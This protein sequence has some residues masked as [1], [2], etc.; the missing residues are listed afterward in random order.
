MASAMDDDGLND[1]GRRDAAAAHWVAQATAGGLEAATRLTWAGLVLALINVL[2][3]GTLSPA[4]MVYLALGIVAALSGAVQ[5]W[6]LVRVTI[7]CRL[8]KVLADVMADSDAGGLAGS[9][10][11]L[12]ALDRA[13]RQLGWLKPGVP[14]AASRNLV[15]R[16][17]GAL[18]LLHWAAV[19]AALQLLAALLLLLLR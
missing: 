3:A 6:L 2:L 8:F 4:G 17:R 12:A 16:A 9:S 19:L 1:G 18:R 10:A 5:L 13:L 11:P 7:D 15:E 14:G